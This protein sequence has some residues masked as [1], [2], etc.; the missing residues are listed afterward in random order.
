MAISGDFHIFIYIEGKNKRRES[1]LSTM[2]DLKG[3]RPECHIHPGG[4]ARPSGY[5][6]PFA[7]A[8]IPTKGKSNGDPAAGHVRVLRGTD[9]CRGRHR[10]LVVQEAKGE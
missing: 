8:V 7:H 5:G 9:A 3:E 6:W 4:S 1:A 10:R 2:I